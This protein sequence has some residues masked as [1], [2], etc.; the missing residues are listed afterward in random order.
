VD[1]ILESD[2]P[3][4]A[5]SGSSMIKA[6]RKAKPMA[7]S[8]KIKLPPHD[9]I[10]STLSAADDRIVLSHWLPPHQGIVPLIRISRRWI[11]ILWAIPIGGRRSFSWSPSHRACGSFKMVKWIAA[12]VRAVVSNA[13]RGRMEDNHGCSAH[14][15][16]AHRAVAHGN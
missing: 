14:A 4:S 11:S 5:D 10:A 16:T 7:E 13:N 9:P 15:K 2:V 6:Q 8:V 3:A 12:C 1:P